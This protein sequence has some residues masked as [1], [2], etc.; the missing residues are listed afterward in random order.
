MK[1]LLE[2]LYIFNKNIR[3]YTVNID[4][5]EIN[6]N[7]MLKHKIA[8]KFCLIYFKIKLSV[9]TECAVK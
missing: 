2:L 8:F 1:Y 4:Y 9:R 5:R 7:F 3:R 6:G